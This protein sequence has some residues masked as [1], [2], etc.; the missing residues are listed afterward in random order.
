MRLMSIIGLVLIGALLPGLCLGTERNTVLPMTKVTG[1]D[2]VSDGKTPDNLVR[3]HGPAQPRAR[4]DLLNLERAKPWSLPTNALADFPKTFEVAIFRFDFQYEETDDPNTTGRGMMNMGIIAPDDWDVYVDTAGHGIDPPPHNALYFHAHMKALRRYWETVSEGKITLNWTIFPG[5]FT[6]AHLDSTYFGDVFDSTA[7]HADSAGLFGT[8]QLLEPMSYYGGDPNGIISGLEKYFEDGITLV[9]QTDP[10]VEFGLYDHYI[11]FHAGADRQND[12]GFPTTSSDLFTGYISYKDSILVDDGDKSVVDATLMPE[13]VS[14]DNRSTA[15]NAVLAHEY[16]HQLGLVDLYRTDKFWSCLGDFALMDHNGFGTAI[17]FGQGWSTGRTF[18][19]M[20]IYPCAWSRAY[21]GFVEVH[22]F[23][24]GID[25]EVVAAEV[26]REGIKVARV[27]ISEN[28][29]YLI[30]N[31]MMMTTVWDPE[32]DTVGMRQDALTSV[33]QGV[34]HWQTKEYTPDYDFLIPGSGVLIYHVDEAVAAMNNS[35]GTCDMVNNFNDNRLQWV[36]GDPNPSRKFVTLIEADGVVDLSGYY[37]TYGEHRYGSARDMFRDDRNRNFTPNTNPAAIDHTYNNTHVR[38]TGISRT[39][40]DPG[41]IRQRTDSMITFD[42]ETDGQIEGFPVRGG[43]P[44]RDQYFSPIVDDLN[45]DGGPE[46]IFASG[47]YVNVVTPTGR[48][49]LHEVSACDPC[50]T[51]YDQVE[52]EFHAEFHP[53]QLHPL[54]LYFD[55]GPDSISANPVTGNFGDNVANKF[56]AVGISYGD[57]GQVQILM[58]SDLDN[59]GLADSVASFVT[60]GSPIAMTFGADLYVLTDSGEVY[61]KSSRDAPP[62]L[63]LDL[64]Y[65]EYHGLM[66]VGAGIIVVGGNYIQSCASCLTYLHYIED[67]TT[68]SDV[69][70]KGDYSLGPITV[71]IDRQ[72]PNEI[73]LCSPDGAIA[74]ASFDHT[75]TYPFV[76]G[77][78]KETGFKFASNPVAGD[79]DD[80]GY[81][82]ILVGGVNTLYAFDRGLTIKPDYPQQ[83][84]DRYT[85]DQVLVAPIVAD[86]ERGN[87]PEM[88]FSTPN[89]NIWSIG[90]DVSFGFPLS[91]GELGIGSPVFFNDSTGGHLGY[92]GLDGWFYLWRVDGDHE[93]DYWTMYGADPTG[94]FAFDASKLGPIQDYSAAFAEEKFFNYPNP[95][96]NGVTKI[97]YFLGQDVSDVKL[98]IYDLAGQ[99]EDRLTGPTSGGLNH[100]VEWVCSDVV[101]GVYRCLIEIDFGGRTETAFTD[102]AVIR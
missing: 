33:L 50:S 102:I 31:R 28:E 69:S 22:D 93:R 19:A 100:D 4:R 94:S 86:L 47:S 66:R 26:A 10:N 68:T 5:G 74:V 3:Q 1:L 92:L 17:D 72:G 25:I 99:V 71:D 70:L 32:S 76:S 83:I 73:V 13:Y 95:V 6:A 64:D 45:G 48:S 62:K 15:L 98:T 97:R 57:S 20:P 36:E 91:G 51:Y 82:E 56:L 80:D 43:V 90:E 75:A 53:G 29:Y 49:F 40:T 18:G 78:I 38:I 34:Y 89:G 21:L 12:I 88:I 87:R 41:G 60:V 2:V 42:V 59:D 52:A 24:Q 55:A 85:T 16:G 101:P 8:Y 79:I 77:R 63:V 54:P 44:L 46:I 58:S 37:Q 14:Q 96:R 84:S 9:D 35:D 81:P 23:R 7:F 30:E 39:L 67:S 65:E 11:M 61:Y 27:P